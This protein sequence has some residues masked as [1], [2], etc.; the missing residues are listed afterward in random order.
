MTAFTVQDLFWLAGIA[1]LVAYW[2]QA[3]GIRDQALGH[4]R[5]YCRDMDVELLDGGLWLRA[6]SLRRD[7]EGSL[8]L[9]RS[10]VFEFTA[11]GDD[12]YHGR[13]TLL[14]RRLERIDLDVHRIH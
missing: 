8:R 2:W 4:I 1:T 13:I 14:G 10:Y 12:R 3:K 6:L 11:T 7:K 9:R 5:R